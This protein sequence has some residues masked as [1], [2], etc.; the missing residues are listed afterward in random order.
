MRGKGNLSEERFPFPRTPNPSKNFRPVGRKRGRR[1]PLQYEN[2][3]TARRGIRSRAGGR[4]KSLGKMRGGEPGEGRRNPFF[5]RLPSPLPRALS[6]H[7]PKTFGFIESLS[8]SVIGR[9]RLSGARRSM[10][11]FRTSRGTYQQ[12]RESPFV[13]P[14]ALFLRSVF[15]FLFL[16]SRASKCR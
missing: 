6:P 15:S 13:P 12:W 2:F 3:H 4:Y 10:S 1:F 11:F 16:S 14:L 5:R 7:P 8:G 9:R